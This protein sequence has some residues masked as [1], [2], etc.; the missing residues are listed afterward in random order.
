MK[1]TLMAVTAAAVTLPLAAAMSP[2]QAAPSAA[3]TV[4]PDARVTAAG[5]L[6][7]LSLAI[8]SNRTRYVSENFKGTLL[9]QR[10]G[11][12]PKAI[13]QS[14]GGAEVGA[15]SVR[16]GVVTF[17]VTAGANTS[18]KRI[19]RAGKVRTVTSLS[20]YERRHNPDGKVR[21]GFRN[22]S[23]SC[24]ASLPKDVPSGYRGIVESHPYASTSTR[25]GTYVADAAAN[26]IFRVDHR[27]RVHTLAVLPAVGV[28]VTPPRAKAVGFPACTIG[29]T[30]YFEPVP[31]DV[32]VGPNGDL[33]VSSLP[34]GPEDPSLGANG[35]VWRIN[36]HNGRMHRVAK[37]LLSPVGL[38]VGRNGDVYVSQLFAGV[39]SRIKH[40]THTAKPWRKVVLPGDVERVGGAIFATANVLSG[41]PGPD[42]PPAGPPNGQVVRL[43]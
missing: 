28:K 31:T 18:L 20:R 19:D 42:G 40:G 5:L 3:R 23:K 10:L 34:G 32:E 17:A 41:M 7:P 36:P 39:V 1:R 27:N 12:K 2:A 43:R 26:A 6:S 4:S 15:V 22:I 21:Y 35:S 33:Y 29:L 25:R 11:H 14:K 24:A 13:F 8:T 9:R 16:N 37:G 38:A 30:Y